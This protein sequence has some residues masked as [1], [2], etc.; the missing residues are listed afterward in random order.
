MEQNTKKLSENYMD[1]DVYVERDAGAFEQI[2]FL[3]KV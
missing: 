2:C 1:I 3:K